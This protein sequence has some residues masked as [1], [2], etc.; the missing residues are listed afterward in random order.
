MSDGHLRKV[1][2]QIKEILGEEVGRLSDPRIGGMVTVTGVSL[3][4]DLSHAT[5]FY[6]LLEGSAGGEEQRGLQSAAGRLQSR[7]G[8]RMHLKNTPRLH[9]EPDPAAEH[10]SRIE[11]ILKEVREGGDH[12]E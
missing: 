8:D 11:D 1:E 7:I 3:S 4:P 12:G 6:S 10:A 5:V 9:F 2:S